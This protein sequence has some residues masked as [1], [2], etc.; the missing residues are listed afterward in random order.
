MLLRANQVVVD[1]TS[2]ALTPWTD[3]TAPFDAVLGI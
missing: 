3:F 2:G 1:A